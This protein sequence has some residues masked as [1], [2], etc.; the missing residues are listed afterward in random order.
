MMNEIALRDVAFT[1][2]RAAD[3]QIVPM[4]RFEGK[5]WFIQT[6]YGWASCDTVEQLVQVAGLAVNPPANSKDAVI[7]Q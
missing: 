5:G 3:W 1:Q 2:L 4:T 6:P 7:P